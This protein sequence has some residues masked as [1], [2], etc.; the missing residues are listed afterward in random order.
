MRRADEPPI[1]PEARASLDAI[2]A[3]LAGE[4]VDPMHAEMA[5]LA[6][7]L[8]SDRPQ[9][10]SLAAD[11]LDAKVARRFA[12]PTSSRKR[13]RWLFAPVAAVALSAVVAVVLVSSV[14]GPR[15]V[16]ESSTSAAAPGLRA[17]SSGAKPAARATSTTPSSGAGAQSASAGSTAAP[18]VSA[19]SASSSAGRPAVAPSAS[20]GT[21]SSSAGPPAAAPSAGTGAAPAPQP[22]A[23]GR[24]IIQS[25]NLNLGVSPNRIDQVAQE[26]FDVVGAQKGIVNRST[27]TATGGADGFAEF[28][29]SV[30]SATLSQTMTELS[31]LRGANVISRTDATQDI[32]GQFVS[33]GR[34]LADARALRSAL[35]KQLADATTT[36]QID[37]LRAQIHDAEASI[38]SDQ[39]T[40][41]RLNQQVNYSQINLTM[42]ARVLPAPVS[43]GGS[44]TIGRAAHDAGRVLTVAAGVGLIVLAALVPVGLVAAAVWWL[45]AGIRRRRREQALDLA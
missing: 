4:A 6:L 25:A 24:K 30:P 34:R 36:T 32:N 31:Q 44:F 37:S 1:G 33:T 2:D 7:L 22:P 14:A 5:E 38:S 43:S 9:M 17:A 42:N 39:A 3:T 27:V 40:L 19:G 29:L 8:A 18:S 20:V 41:R 45:A 21:A 35:L 12:P 10:A 11:A 23:S 26:V 16:S 15:S 13:R 28:Q